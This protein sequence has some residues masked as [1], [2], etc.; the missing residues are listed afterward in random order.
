MIQRESQRLDSGT[1]DQAVGRLEAHHSAEGGR[2]PDGPARIGAS[3]HENHIRGDCGPGTAARPARRTLRIARVADRAEVRIVGGDAVGEFVQS[4][5]TQH[6]GAGVRQLL[7]NRGVEVRN[8]IGK[9]FR[10]RSSADAL[11]R[12]QVLVCNRNTV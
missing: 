7:D 4:G 9:Q 11:G 12:D 3:G 1:I 8:I 6:H 5:L 10:A 2:D